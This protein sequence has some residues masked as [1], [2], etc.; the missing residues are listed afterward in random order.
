MHILE[1]LICNDA[2]LMKNEWI[3]GSDCQRLIEEPLGKFRV[4]CETV[5]KADV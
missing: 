3:I 4:V 1:A 5:L 2:D